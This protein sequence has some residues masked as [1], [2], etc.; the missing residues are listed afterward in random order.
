M[1]VEREDKRRQGQGQGQ[2]Q[3]HDETRKKIKMGMCGAQCGRG[4]LLI[5]MEMT[6]PL[7]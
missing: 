2:G 7:G 6:A 3:G 4:V 5:H 1:A